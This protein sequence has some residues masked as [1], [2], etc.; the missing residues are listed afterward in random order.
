MIAGKVRRRHSKASVRDR[1]VEEKLP[2]KGLN[3][4]VYF[5]VNL[6]QY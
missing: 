6:K 3:A 1:P 5:R 2:K 4:Y